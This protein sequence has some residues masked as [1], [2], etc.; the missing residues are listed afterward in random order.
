MI[1]SDDLRGVDIDPMEHQKNMSV[2]N[3]NMLAESTS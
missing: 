2:D 3:L 1:I